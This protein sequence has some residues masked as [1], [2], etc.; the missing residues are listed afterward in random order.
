MQKCLSGRASRRG[1]GSAAIS[2]PI[3]QGLGEVARM[4]RAL[5]FATDNVRHSD[6]ARLAIR[7]VNEAMRRQQS[8]CSAQD[9]WQS[10]DNAY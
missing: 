1:A 6:A 9:L 8:S 10:I 4:N 2:H 3:R 7:Y 5:I